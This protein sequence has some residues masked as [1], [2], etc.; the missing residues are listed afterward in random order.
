MIDQTP[1][2][3]WKTAWLPICAAEFAEN[4]HGVEVFCRKLHFQTGKAWL[5]FDVE[6]ELEATQAGGLIE[7][8]QPTPR[9]EPEAEA[10]MP[11]AQ[12]ES[13]DELA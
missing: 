2:I 7:T 1:L 3:F 9:Q 11:E 12:P 5:D 10:T 6:N 8:I 13:A 4:A